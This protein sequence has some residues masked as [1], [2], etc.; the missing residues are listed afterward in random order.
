MGNIFCKKNKFY[1]VVFTAHGFVMSAA[2]EPRHS[3]QPHGLAEN[4]F[5][6][7]NPSW[8]QYI[9]LIVACTVVKQS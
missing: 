4:A 7:I 6:Y 1:R 3:A 8:W 2:A 9:F 5:F